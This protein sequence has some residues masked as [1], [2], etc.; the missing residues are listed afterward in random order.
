MKKFVIAL[1]ALLLVGNASIVSAADQTPFDINVILSLTGPGA[2]LGNGEAKT[3]SALQS[4]INKTGGIR[5]RPVHFAINDDQSS[6]QLAVQLADSLK[7]KNVAVIMGPSYTATCYAVLPLVK[8]GPVQYCYT[9]SVHTTAPSYTFSASVS[10]KDLAFAG[11]RWLRL[12]G[13]RKVAILVTTDATG[14]DGETVLKQDLQAPE[15]ASMQLVSTE[16]Y[17]PTDISVAAQISRIKAAGAEAVVVWVTGTPFGTALKGAQDAGLTI[18]MLT[19]A[20]NLSNVEMNQ[21]QSLVPKELYFTG[22][23]FQAYKVAGKGP[24]KDAQEQFVAAM[25]SVGVP[26]VDGTGQQAWDATSIVIDAYRHL[27]TNATAEQIRSYIANLH[28]YAGIN[29]IMDFRDGQQRGL[30]EGSAVIVRWDGGKQ[31][32]IPVSKPGGALLP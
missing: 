7:A 5:G 15:M 29:G 13:V 9:P 17:G 30:Q 4:V 27:G 2:F 11:L 23:R 6:P 16:H 22:F 10:T 14:Q 8:S 12:R 1:C 20:G 18:P 31:D 28:G 21:Y 25:R 24:V 26:K 19:D 3:L 32:W